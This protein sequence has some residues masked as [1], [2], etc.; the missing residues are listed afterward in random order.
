MTQSSDMTPDVS[1]KV[2]AIILVPAKNDADFNHWT[3]QENVIKR[4]DFN[5]MK[6]VEEINCLSMK[7]VSHQ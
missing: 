3:P 7:V 5:G 1:E 2:A 4:L 6:F